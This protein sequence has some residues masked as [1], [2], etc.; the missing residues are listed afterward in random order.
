MPET[1][2]KAVFKGALVDAIDVPIIQSESRE[3]WNE[4]KLED[5]ATIRLRYSVGFVTRIIDEYDSDGNP[6]YAIKGN[7]VAVTAAPEQLRKK[8]G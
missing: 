2:T 5:G 8:K 3:N 7:V 1:K 4:Y 6:V